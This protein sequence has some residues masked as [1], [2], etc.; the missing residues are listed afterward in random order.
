MTLFKHLPPNLREEALKKY[1]GKEALRFPA[2]FALKLKAKNAVLIN[3]TDE[4]GMVI[5]YHDYAMKEFV[6]WL[7][8]NNIEH[9]I[10]TISS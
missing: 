3:P 8:S 7:C 9:E 6:N 2:G 10:I 5:M 1:A 4:Y